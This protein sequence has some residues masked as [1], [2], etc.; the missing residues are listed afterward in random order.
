MRRIA[1][2]SYRVVST[3]RGRFRGRLSIPAGFFLYILPVLVLSLCCGLLFFHHLAERDLWSSH[4]ARAAQEAQGILIHGWGRLPHL[5]DGQLDVQKPP[6]YY[7]LVALAARGRGTAVDAWAVRLPAALAGWAGVLLLFG[8]GVACGRSRAGF[9]AALVLA[10]AQHYTWLA[11][12]GRIDMPLTLCV[13]VALGAYY[14]AWKRRAAW[15]WLILVYLAVAVAVLLKGPIGAVLPIVVMVSHWL[16][17]RRWRAGVTSWRC[18]SLWWGVPL[19]LALVGPYFWW[20]DRQSG[21][22]FTQSFFWYHNLQRGLGGAEALAAKP[23]WFYAPRLAFDFLPWTPALAGAAW[24]GWRRKGFARD[25]EARF[26]LLWAASMVLLL[27]LMRFKRAD[28]LLPA[29]PGLA[30]F[31]GCA[32]DQL[33]ATKAQRRRGAWGLAGVIVACLVGWWAYVVHYLP[34]LEP[35]RE[36]RAFAAAIRQLAPAPRPVLFFRTEAHALAF[37]LGPPL[38]TFLEWENLDVWASRRGYYIVMTPEDAAAWPRH[39]SSGT[40]VEVLRNTDLAGGA[41]AQPLVV[42]RTRPHRRP[43]VSHTSN[44]HVDQ[45]GTTSHRHRGN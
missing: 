40:L 22:A 35:Q 7:W 5:Y 38:N 8:W 28:Y 27:S 3:A 16:L 45:L 12:T 13:G 10:T 31:L 39:V 19:V 24:W 9:G 32:A 4:E 25:P 42:V 26:G 18:S 17:E 11:R 6:L 2:P 1:S 14:V 30:L 43:T 20:L 36:H 21:G 37:H 34:R 15:P 44:H 23:W 33:F 41:H 29:F